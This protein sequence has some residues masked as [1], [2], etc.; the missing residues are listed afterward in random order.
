MGRFGYRRNFIKGFG[1]IAQPLYD[2]MGTKDVPKSLRKKNG[3]VRGKAVDLV[4]NEKALESF[5]ELRKL[6][7]S[8]LTLALPDFS[9]PFHLYT[10]A[11]DYAYGAH[12]TQYKGNEMEELGYFSK[13]YT[14]AQRKYATNEK[15]LLVIVRAIEFFHP[16]LYGRNFTVWSDQLPLSYIFTMKNPSKRLGRWIE[17]LWMY[18][19]VIKY[20]PGKENTIADYLSRMRDENEVNTD[21][22]EDFNDVLVASIEEADGQEEEG[23]ESTAQTKSAVVKDHSEGQIP[24]RVWINVIGLEPSSEI[25]D[26]Y[27]IYKQEQEKDVN[28]V[29]IRE[30]ILRHGDDRPKVLLFTDVDQRILYKEYH[31]LRIL[32]DLV[33]RQGEDFNGLT[34]VQLV[35]SKEMVNGILDGIHKVAYGGHLGRKKTTAKMLDR[36]YRPGLREAIKSY[37]RT[38]DVCQKVKSLNPKITAEMRILSPQYTNQMIASDFAGPFKVTARGNKYIQVITDLF[39]KTLLIKATTS[40]LAQVAAENIAHDWCCTYG[41]PE[42]C[43]TDGGREYQSKVW[44][45]L[46]ELLDIQRLKTTPFHPQADG[47]SER[48]VQTVKRMIASFVDE[49]Q[50]NW[51]LN[52]PQ[53]TFAYNSSVHRMT[54]YS[55][56]EVMLARKPR[57]PLDLMYP[58]QSDL[59]RPHREA[60]ASISF[61]DHV[62]EFESGHEEIDEFDQME[63]IDPSTLLSTN[64]ANYVNQCK[65]VMETCFA[66]VRKNKST[67]MLQAKEYTDR[68][69][70]K[71]S[72]SVGDLVLCNHPYLKHGASRG[73]AIK[74]YGPFRII[75]IN[76]NGCDYLIKKH[77]SPRSRIRHIHKNNIK[78]YFDRGWDQLEEIEPSQE[79]VPKRKYTKNPNVARWNNRVEES[80]SSSEEE[81]ERELSQLASPQLS[82]SSLHSDIISEKDENTDTDSSKESSDSETQ[83]GTSNRLGKRLTKPIQR[84][85]YG[86]RGKRNSKK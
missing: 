82:E 30:L 64:V 19:F 33:Y 37:I 46:C 61:A 54:G 56:F 34:S 51:D 24:E 32:N 6:A 53:L 27:E 8:A 10:D 76:K 60:N 84:L 28:I 7:S 79:V 18:D 52:L 86:H 31:K 43:L 41:I 44:D 16:L 9:Q 73:L 5:Y 75:G 14:L 1:E 63:D 29:W 25:P 39:S 2:I 4:W 59:G 36:F 74:Y 66:H 68:K 55:P 11:S 49:A 13:S 85:N 81:T 77:K 42:A 22:N 26:L 71:K 38:C 78:I 83:P 20:I 17:M 21:P 35:I 70:K 40:K 72:Y 57:I 45:A 23:E 48:A 62:D 3:Q 69:I 58:T 12:L 65:D 80:H 15:E 47:Q 67:R 50:D